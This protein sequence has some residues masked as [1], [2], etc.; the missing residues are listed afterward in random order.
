MPGQGH[1]SNARFWAY[2]GDEKR[3]Y[4]VF[5]FTPTRERAGPE[6]FLDGFAGYLQADAYGVYDGIYLKSKGGIQEV[7]CW[8]HDRRY[9]WDARDNDAPRAHVALGYISRLYEVERN[10]E[11]AAVDERA[12]ARRRYSRPILDDFKTWLDAE[13]IPV[14]PKS[15]IGKAFTYTLNQWDALCR[16][17]ERGDLCIDNNIAEQTVKI[18]AIGRKNWLFV[19][20]E[21]GGDRAAVLFSLIASCKAN[22]VEPYAYL[23]DVI[24]RLPTH[25]SD[26]IDELLP[27][28]WLKSHPE[29][30]W[31]IDDVRRA[32]RKQSEA[33]RRDR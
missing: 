13:E 8:A 29:H 21:T 20:S 26:R 12:A 2:I 14:L 18:V 10:F 32:E 7:A 9:W 27:D 23:R 17:I 16:Y 1:A 25:P 22:Q 19:A 5:D 3:P 28:V 4:R 11:S 30:R 6:Q 24:K 33:S 31:K 15:V